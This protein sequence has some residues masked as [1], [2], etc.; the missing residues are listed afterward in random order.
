VT[1][2]AAHLWP[3]LAGALL[4]GL[5]VG[6]LAG[7]PGRLALA[8]GCAGLAALAVAASLV[9]GQAG[10]RLEGAVL[11][12]AAYLVGAAASTLVRRGTG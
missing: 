10:L 8:A 9:P 1:L 4:L 11:M 12:L 3:W 5:G 2:V 7:P 6:A